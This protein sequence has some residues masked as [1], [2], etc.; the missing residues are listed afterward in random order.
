MSNSL[1]Y[2]LRN[3]RRRSDPKAFM[4]VMDAAAMPGRG[5]RV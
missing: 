5:H 3:I 1:K 4:V 2:E